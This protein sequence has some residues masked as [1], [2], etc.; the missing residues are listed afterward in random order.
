L[1]FVT[2]EKRPIAGNKTY[3]NYL[4]HGFLILL[5]GEKRASILF[6]IIRIMVTKL[7]HIKIHVIKRNPLL[8]TSKGFYTYVEIRYEFGRLYRFI[9]T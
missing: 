5:Q 3:R 6:P 9:Y 8:S 4:F 2:L 1:G 7:I